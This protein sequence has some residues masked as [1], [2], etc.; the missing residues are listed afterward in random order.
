MT[1]LLE[2]A[3][4][5][6]HTDILSATTDHLYFVVPPDP[7]EVVTLSNLGNEQ[8]VIHLCTT[9]DLSRLNCWLGGDLQLDRFCMLGGE[10]R[11]HSLLA[12]LGAADIRDRK[13]DACPVGPTLPTSA[14]LMKATLPHVHAGSSGGA[15]NL[16]YFVVPPVPA[17]VVT[18]PPL[19]TEQPVVHLRPA[20]QCGLFLVGAVL[21]LGE[22][23][24]FGANFSC[25]G[26]L[27][28]FLCFCFFSYFSEGFGLGQGSA[29]GQIVGGEVIS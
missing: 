7:A 17:E 15:P 28:H 22:G 27:G 10:E 13:G 19:G 6:I 2:A 29:V 20:R 12:F 21:L 23:G 24:F 3:F 9:S 4:P 16:L 14:T 5:H 18:P 1:T 26:K 25:L 11:I 8:P